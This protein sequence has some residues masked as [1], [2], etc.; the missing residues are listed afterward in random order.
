L[1]GILTGFASGRREARVLVRQLAVGPDDDVLI[2]ALAGNW[3]AAVCGYL[4]FET[5]LFEE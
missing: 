2:Y 5:L 1:R 4:I 3:I